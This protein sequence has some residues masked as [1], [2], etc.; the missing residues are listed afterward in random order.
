MKSLLL[1]VALLVTACGP[2]V[3]D[4]IEDLREELPTTV[5]T[6]AGM[7]IIP[8]GW[9]LHLYPAYCVALLRDRSG[10]AQRCYDYRGMP[11]FG[12]CQPTSFGGCSH[13][14]FGDDHP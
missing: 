10:V 1:V 14:G 13:F 12:D 7:E 3:K 6:P 9:F 5:V 8:A 4:P 2:E 11:D